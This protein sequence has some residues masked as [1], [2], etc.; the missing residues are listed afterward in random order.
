MGSMV[1]RWT[2]PTASVRMRLPSRSGIRGAWQDA[3]GAQC[4]QILETAA[5]QTG[6]VRRSKRT[7]S[8]TH[9]SGTV[10]RDECGGSESAPC[11]ATEVLALL[12]SGPA[13]MYPQSRSL[14]VSCFATQRL[15][16]GQ[17]SR[18]SSLNERSRRGTAFSNE[19]LCPSCRIDRSA[20]V[21]RGLLISYA[22]QQEQSR[23]SWSRPGRLRMESAW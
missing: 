14:S 23:S 1:K 20:Q 13:L 16:G 4:H 5:G 8:S 12:Q 15:K 9:A 3:P 10:E 11:S 21:T 19:W 22:P 18:W 2:C 7:W 6:A 17:A